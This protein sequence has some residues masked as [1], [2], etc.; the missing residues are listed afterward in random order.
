VNYASESACSTR[1][2]VT[3]NDAQHNS[4]FLVLQT[5]CSNSR[6]CLTMAMYFSKEGSIFGS[7]S[8]ETE[9]SG[10]NVLSEPAGLAE[11]PVVGRSTTSR[12]RSEPCT[13]SLH[14]YY[15]KP[16]VKLACKRE[17]KIEYGTQ[18]HVIFEY[19]LD[20]LV[21]HPPSKNKAQSNSDVSTYK[22]DFDYFHVTEFDFDFVDTRMR[23]YLTWLFSLNQF[24]KPYF[25]SINCQL[26]QLQFT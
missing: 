11:R 9:C 6:C 3:D 2:F 21:P 13:V 1:S 23:C 15:M 4:D 7:T 20:R 14:Y 26:C 17:I 10:D 24:I 12:E 22:S 25:S 18:H 19:F 5:C 16:R 8:A